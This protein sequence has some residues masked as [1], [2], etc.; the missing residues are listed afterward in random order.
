[1][2]SEM[3]DEILK[4]EKSALTIIERDNATETTF[5][6]PVCG[7]VA[8]LQLHEWLGFTSRCENSCF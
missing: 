4:A 7:A 8:R 2:H 6:C 5:S 3:L 1:M